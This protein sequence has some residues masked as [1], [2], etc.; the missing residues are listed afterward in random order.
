MLRTIQAT[1]EAAYQQ[2]QALIA[3]YIAW[4]RAAPVS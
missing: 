1:S 3:E 4:D 2:I